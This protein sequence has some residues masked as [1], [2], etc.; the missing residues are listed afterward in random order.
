MWIYYKSYVNNIFS[1][2][3]FFLQWENQS[4]A[5]SHRDS[6]ATVNNAALRN[7]YA[8]LST[9]LSVCYPSLLYYSSLNFDS[10]LHADSTDKELPKVN[11][12]VSDGNDALADEDNDALA[13][14]DN[15]ALADKDND[16]LLDE[17]ND[18]EDTDESDVGPHHVWHAGLTTDN[19]PMPSHCAHNVVFLK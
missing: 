16:A 11:D 3:V 12:G 10:N 8:Y 4:L 15:D 18:G 19:C 7:N 5:S 1:V 13:D 2:S 6:T 17:D 9:Y 14:K